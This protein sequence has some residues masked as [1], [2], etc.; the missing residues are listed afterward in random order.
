[1][2]L[3]RSTP[4]GIEI[5]LRKIGTMRPKNT[6]LPPC[7]ANQASVRS[8]SLTLSNGVLAKTHTARSRPKIAP[9]Q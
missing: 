3:I 1:M 7:L 9:S 5:R 6:A 4:A 8:R 2:K